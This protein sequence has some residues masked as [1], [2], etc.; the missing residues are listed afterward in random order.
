M[1]IWE[2]VDAF[3]IDSYHLP[4]SS[5]CKLL[6][7]VHLLRSLNSF[8]QAPLLLIQNL[9][10]YLVP[11][12][13]YT[14]F[15]SYSRYLPHTGNH[16]LSPQPIEPCRG[17]LALIRRLYLALFTLPLFPS[18]AYPAPTVSSKTTQRE[19]ALLPSSNPLCWVFMLFLNPLIENGVENGSLGGGFT[20]AELDDIEDQLFLYPLSFA[21]LSSDL[22]PFFQ[23]TQWVGLLEPRGARTQSY[24]F[25]T[26]SNESYLTYLLASSKHTPTNGKRRPNSEN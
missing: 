1:R 22:L 9:L 3:S 7:Q 8:R 14:I 2:D 20:S 15:I 24:V 11:Y 25:T 16:H 13:V 6:L 21:R 26:I 19:Y 23:N 10:F 17:L 18:Q 5:N 12:S 4:P